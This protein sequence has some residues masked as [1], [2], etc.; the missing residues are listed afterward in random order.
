MISKKYDNCKDNL[1]FICK[2]HKEKGIQEK[3]LDKIIHRN[4]GCKYCAYERLGKRTRISTDM[5]IKRC[6]EL[7]IKYI[8]RY[9]FNGET[10]IK[11]ICTKHKN[12]GVQNISW[13]HLKTCSFGCPHFYGKYKTTEDFIT[14]IKTINSDIKIIG[15]YKGSEIP[16]KCQ[17]IKCGHI[18][19]PIGRSLKYGQGCPMCK[20]S[21][22]EKRIS[23]FLQSHKIKFESEMK[24]QN[25]KNERMLRFDFYLP[26]Y[27]L[28][29][30]Y[31][32]EQHYKPVDFANKGHKW[33]VSLYEQNKERDKI[34]NQFCKN[35]NIQM[36]RIPHWELNNI[37]NILSKKLGVKS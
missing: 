19:S 29:I 2:Y 21:K 6:N 20:S 22:G 27:N 26:D 12:K 17:C 15:E 33:A 13:Y 11:Y 24:F 4:Q 9:S 35:H 1:K 32:G 5:I 10:W 36:L 28:C 7:E 14:E 34:K 18:W 16:I 31:D 8:D 25:C 23:N 37:E 3:T 30:E